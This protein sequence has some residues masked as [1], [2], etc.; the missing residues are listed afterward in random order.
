VVD[1]REVVVQNR[2][3]T[4][5][6]ACEGDISWLLSQIAKLDAS[7]PH[8]YSLMPESLPVR[9]R[10][11]R[12]LVANHP[13]FVAEKSEERLGF[14]TGIVSPH[15][16]NPELLVCYEALW[17]VSPRYRKTRA[18][19]MLLDRFTEWCRENVDWVF[20]SLHWTT[21]VSGRHLEKRGY[22]LS[23]SQ[24]LMEV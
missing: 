5:R 1:T 24:F 17:Y 8:K 6:V 13:F 9:M 4:V 16:L 12:N 22:R 18:A 10:I 19:V 11:L 3:V 23:E 2:S 7:V 15:V 14:V 20:F 21:E